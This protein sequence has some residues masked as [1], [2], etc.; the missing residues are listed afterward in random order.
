MVLAKEDMSLRNSF[1]SA[2][3]AIRR[4]LVV[5]GDTLGSASID[6]RQE[7]GFGNLVEVANNGDERCSIVTAGHDGLS[8][9]AASEC[10]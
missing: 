6:Q 4:A 2:A 10:S 8:Y 5:D 1:T 9:V 7:I 3:P